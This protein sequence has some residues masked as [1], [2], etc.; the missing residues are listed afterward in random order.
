M[1]RQIVYGSINLTSN[2]PGADVYLNGLAVGS[3]NGSLPIPKV[4]PGSVELLLVLEGYK[5]L[6]KKLTVKEGDTLSENVTLVKN[7]GAVFGK[8]WENGINMRF[9]PVGPD[10]MVSIWET[11]VRDYELFVKESGHKPARSPDYPQ[12]PDYPVV[13]ITRED[14]QAFCEWL[15]KRERKDERI[16]QSHV[17]RLPTDLEWSMMAG[18]HE[19]EGISPG[20]RDARKERVYPWG[21]NWPNDKAVGNFADITASRTP[22]VSSDQT[23]P[24]Y[25]DGFAYAA[26]VG[27]FDPNSYGLYDLSGNV[28]EWV[29]DEYSK[30]GNNLLGVLRGGGWN[31][32]QPE[33]LFTGS[34]NAVPPT[35]QDWI[36]GFRVVLAKVPPKAE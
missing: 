14:A 16:A 8:P 32:Y 35:F 22:G 10:L 13:H 1:V 2:P 6:S 26:P 17:Y 25:D 11:R 27:S 19:E 23:I 18:L 15:T 28:Q 24:D 30:L 7:Q 33:N 9:A 29:E 34:R 36:Y 12:T 4:K 21:A 5:P 3:T 31:T 20:W